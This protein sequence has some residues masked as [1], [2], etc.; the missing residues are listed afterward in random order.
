MSFD[1]LKETNG[2]KR[3]EVAGDELATPRKKWAEPAL[4]VYGTVAE[5]TRVCD[6]KTHGKSDAIALKAPPIQCAS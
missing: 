4:A 6:D 1:T 3:S 5:I 2:H